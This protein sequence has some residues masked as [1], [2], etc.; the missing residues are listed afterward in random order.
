MADQTNNNGCTLHQ[1]RRNRYFY[2]KLM[3][4]RDFETEQSYINDKRHLLNRMIHGAGII[5]GFSN[6]ALKNDGGAV[7]IVFNTGGTALD[8][9]GNEIVVS[10]DGL[11][12]PVYNGAVPLTA[13]LL[14]TGT[15]YLYL[16]YNETEAES[17]SAIVNPSSCEEKCCNNRIVES[18]TVTAVTTPPTTST[19]DCTDVDAGKQ[20]ALE[21]KRWVLKQSGSIRNCDDQSVFLAAV[22]ANLNIPPG[23]S[24][25]SDNFVDADTTLTYRPVIYNNQL[26][27]QLISCHITDPNPHDMMKGIQ[28]EGQ[29][30]DNV[31]GYVTLAATDSIT[32]DAD[33]GN[34]TVTVGESHSAV[35]GNPHQ[36]VHSQLQGILAADGSIVTDTTADKH[37]THQQAGRWD[38]AIYKI[39]GMVPKA[40]TGNFTIS[41]GTNVTVTASTN[42]VTISSTASGGLE[43]DL[44]TFAVNWQHGQQM[45]LD[46]F[47]SRMLNQDFVLEFSNTVTQLADNTVFS[48]ALMVPYV[49]DQDKLRFFMSRLQYLNGNVGPQPGSQTSSM[50][51]FLDEVTAEELFGY[52]HSVMDVLKINE[53]KQMLRV[54]IQVKCDFIPDVAGRAVAGHHLLGN[55]KSGLNVNGSDNLQGGLFESWIDLVQ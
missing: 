35:A 54:M 37:I 10:G 9:C 32:L 18:F 22:T 27:S 23:S 21:L 47:I 38:S 55:G 39:N 3:S 44:T 15:Y 46:E 29:G 28:A 5:R 36:T 43:K 2:G 24:V 26:L 41:G 31:N 45:S 16:N 52:L 7:E 34:H 14:A 50:H 51:Y 6:M 19:I 20:T 8:C 30:V 1:F 40:D 12:V 49:E 13:A 11:S 4:V 25:N 48:F 42:K 17:V 33:S 53:R